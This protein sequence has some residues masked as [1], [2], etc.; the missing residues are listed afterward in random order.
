MDKYDKELVGKLKNR[1]NAYVPRSPT[2]RRI[3]PQKLEHGTRTLRHLVERS[4]AATLRPDGHRVSGFQGY[5]QKLNEAAALDDEAILKMLKVYKT[6]LDEVFFFGLL[7]TETE[8]KAGPRPL[9]KVRVREGSS[10]TKHAKYDETESAITIY[11]RSEWT[12]S[13]YVGTLAHEMCHAYIY[14]FAKNFPDTNN[15]DASP[16]GYHSLDWCKLFTF[17][18][19]K[20]IG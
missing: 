19:G 7:N 9:V 8:W 5:V 13:D 15:P 11:T 4:S 12:V 20:L 1:A 16:Q 10:S 17:V 2:L 18:I 3:L 14:I 6:R